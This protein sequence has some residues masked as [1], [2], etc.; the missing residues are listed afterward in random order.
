MDRGLQYYTG[1][2]KQ[3]H[4]KEKGKQEDKTS[5]E[6]LWIAEEQREV[7]NKEERERYIQL[8]TE[9]QKITRSDRNKWTMLLQWKMLNN[10]KQQQKEKD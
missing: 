6:A 3:N 9:F 7:K 8:N 2:G 10:W 4:P 5:E 1:G